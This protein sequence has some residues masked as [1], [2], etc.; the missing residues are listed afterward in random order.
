LAEDL[1]Q[2]IR[3]MLA[4]HTTDREITDFLVQRYGDF[5]LYRPPWKATTLVL[6]LGPFVLLGVGTVAL[7]L[8]L[9]RRAQRLREMPLT[10]EEQRR[11]ERWLSDGGRS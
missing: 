3:E 6:W 7:V 8:V 10:D 5:V 9:R 2:E 11:V 1:R 4:K